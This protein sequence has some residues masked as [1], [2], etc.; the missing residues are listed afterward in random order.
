MTISEQQKSELQ[1]AIVDMEVNQ[2][3]LD[4]LITQADIMSKRVIEIL[5][6]IKGLNK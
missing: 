5:N 2:Q 1:Q 6:R 4:R 3:E